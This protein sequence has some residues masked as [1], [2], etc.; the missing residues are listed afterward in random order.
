MQ[1]ENL[2][3]QKKKPDGTDFIFFD[4]NLAFTKIKKAFIITFF[5]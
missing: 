2:I 4:I 3:K 1:N 5:L